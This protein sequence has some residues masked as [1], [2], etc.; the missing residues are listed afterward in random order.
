M[1]TAGEPQGSTIVDLS[2]EIYQGMPV[3]PGH[4]NTVIWDYHTH[5][6]TVDVMESDL[7]Y[8]TRGIILSDHGPT[9]VD[10]LSHFDPREG[11]ATIDEMNLDLFHGPAICIDISAAAPRTDVATGSGTR[12]RRRT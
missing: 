4:L 2:Q 1:P 5:E 7:T 10:S 12:A 6:N 9:H 3:F 11:A 8:A